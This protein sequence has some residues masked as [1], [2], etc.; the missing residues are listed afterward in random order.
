MTGLEKKIP[1]DGFLRINRSAIVN[2]GRIKELHPMFHG[3]YVI[4]L[5]NGTQ[6][7]L[8]RSYR[9]KFSRL[10]LS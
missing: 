4:V 5:H 8:T 1:S 6:L 2:L 3:E 7:T 10:G 9:D